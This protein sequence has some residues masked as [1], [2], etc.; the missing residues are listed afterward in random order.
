MYAKL[1]GNQL[2]SFNNFW[3]SKGRVNEVLDDGGSI[4]G[5]FSEVDFDVILAHSLVP[6]V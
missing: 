1:V 5:I 2:R 4:L 3:A 6:G